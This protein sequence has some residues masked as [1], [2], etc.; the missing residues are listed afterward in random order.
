M[1]AERLTKIS[2]SSRSFAGGA[3]VYSN[4]LKTEFAG[5]DPKLIERHGAVSR[6]VAAA[7][8]QGIRK[9]CHTTLGA[10]V[11]GIAGPSGGSEDKPVGLVYLGLS[12][13]DETEV[14]E[15]RFGGDR[16][17]IRHYASQTALDMVRR[18]LM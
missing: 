3:V 10:G 8:A 6:E 4:E 11:T 15:R 5:V 13:G 14:L 17:R 18:R 12:D 1:I 16:E 7:L 2:G 9:R